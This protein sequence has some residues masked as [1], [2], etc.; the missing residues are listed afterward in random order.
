MSDIT[1]VIS[2]ATLYFIGSKTVLFSLSQWK[3]FIYSFFIFLFTPLRNWEIILYIVYFT[4]AFPEILSFFGRAKRYK[5]RY[6][7]N[8]CDA[9]SRTFMLV[10]AFFAAFVPLRARLT[11]SLSIILAKILTAALSI[12]NYC[13][14]Y[15]AARVQL[16]YWMISECWFYRQRGCRPACFQ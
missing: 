4:L 11:V 9:T 8:T 14:S 6:A 12:V 1:N 16:R 10:D 15:A 13:R 3:L 2:L 7:N 5:K